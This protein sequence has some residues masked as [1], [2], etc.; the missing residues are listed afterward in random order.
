MN[1]YIEH[2]ECGS[3]KATALADW[4]ISHGIG[5]LSTDEVAH[6]LGIP[7]AH[8]PQRLAPL[9][10][11]SELF[12]PARGLWVPVPAEYREWG[13]PD[14]LT[15]IDDTM[16]FLG[17]DYRVGW[18]SAAAIHGAS[19]HAAQVFQVATDSTV[20]N[21]VC[22]RSRLEFFSRRYV[23]SLTVAQGVPAAREAKVATVGATMLMLADDPNLCGGL[24]NVANLVVELSEDAPEFAVELMADAAVFHDAAARRVGWLLDTFAGGAPEGLAAYCA[25]L[26]SDPSFLSSNRKQPGKRD[27]KWNLIINEEVDPDL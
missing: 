19:H 26:G 7:T 8:V 24:N 23:G 16:S 9:R 13:A 15:Y 22:G 4:A 25:E 6:L 2:T 11:R 14:P 27:G 18:L 20:R 5:A 17:V 21:R 3:V 12:S 10:K 1:P